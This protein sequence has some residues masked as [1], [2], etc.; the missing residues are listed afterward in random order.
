MGANA[1]G[2]QHMPPNFQSN[3]NQMH[4]SMPHLQ[5]NYDSMQMQQWNHQP[6]APDLSM[7]NNMIQNLNGHDENTQNLIISDLLKSSI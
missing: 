2:L 5:H 7:I 6:N 3:P 1:E 4:Y